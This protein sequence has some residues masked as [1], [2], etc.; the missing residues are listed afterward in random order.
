MTDEE[1]ITQIKAS[2][3]WPAFTIH[4]HDFGGPTKG[5]VTLETLRLWRRDPQVTVNELRKLTEEEADAIYAVLYL[6]P[7]EA[8]QDAELRH[9]LVDLGVLRGPRKAAQ[10]LQDIVGAESDGWIGPKTLA[11]MSHFEPHDLLV[12]LIG[13]RFAHI[14]QRVRDDPTQRRW[15]P[16]WRARNREFLT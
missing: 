6:K 13:A 12:M 4:P 5:G 11:A 2:E 3:G 14:A 9:Y 10:M 1:I 8:I 16:G 7:F 15:E